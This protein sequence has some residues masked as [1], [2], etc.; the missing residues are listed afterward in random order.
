[1]LSAGCQQVFVRYRA[2]LYHH[3]HLPQ[4]HNL[5]KLEGHKYKGKAKVVGT[6]RMKLEPFPLEVWI[7]ILTPAKRIRCEILGKDHV[8][9]MNCLMKACLFPAVCS[10]KLV[11]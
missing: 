6:V 5:S 9:T 8:V 10:Q 11:V 4:G 2:H 1:M 3:L 7:P